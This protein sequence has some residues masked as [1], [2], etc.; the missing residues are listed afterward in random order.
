M[1]NILKHALHA[2][3]Q[4]KQALDDL[5]KTR[6]DAAHMANLSLVKRDARGPK[7]GRGGKGK[8]G[9]KGADKSNDKEQKARANPRRLRPKQMF[10]LQRNRS[11]DQRLPKEKTS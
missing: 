9:D 8:N 4:E 10:L 6:E 1:K 7:R 3:L 5:K 2:E 11:L